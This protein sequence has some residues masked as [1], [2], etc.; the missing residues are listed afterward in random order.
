MLDEKPVCTADME[1]QQIH[2]ERAERPNRISE[3]E[4]TLRDI[5]YE[6]SG[7]QGGESGGI[8]KRASSIVCTADKRAAQPEPT[9]ANLG[10]QAERF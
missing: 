4:R 6:I 7:L 1:I 5:I 2:A 9:C 10:P 3:G 8:P